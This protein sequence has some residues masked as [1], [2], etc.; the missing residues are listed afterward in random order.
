VLTQTGTVTEISPTAVTV[1]SEDGF[2]QAYVIPATA[3]NAGPPFAVNDQVVVRATRDGQTATVTNI[4][5][6]PQ[7]GPHHN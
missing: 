1:R 7:G 6:P 5:N 4:G 2:T 3:G